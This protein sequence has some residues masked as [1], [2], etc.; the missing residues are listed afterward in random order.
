MSSFEMCVC[1]CVL[2]TNRSQIISHGVRIHCIANC[3][4]LE[5]SSFYK[6]VWI[7]LGTPKE[8]Q[9]NITFDVK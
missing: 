6:N 9:K 1:V 7:N 2:D 8:I 5:L 4:Y 3:T